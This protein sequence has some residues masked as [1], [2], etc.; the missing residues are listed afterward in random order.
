M[1]WTREEKTFAVTILKQNHLKMCKQNFA[2][3]II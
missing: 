2:G 3:S 1:P